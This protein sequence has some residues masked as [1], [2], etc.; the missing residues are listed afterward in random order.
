MKICENWSKIGEGII[1][2]YP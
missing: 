2:F 1:G